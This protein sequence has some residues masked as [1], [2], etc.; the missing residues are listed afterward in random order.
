MSAVRIITT[1]QA[2]SAKPLAT[3]LPV[4]TDWQTIIDVPVYDVPVVGFGS[5][6]RIA[7]GVAE[8]SS[9][10]FMTNTSSSNV[11]TVDVR[12]VR[13]ERPLIAGQSQT[14]FVDQ[15]DAG[16]DYGI[17]N[18]IILESNAAVTVTNVDGNGSVTEFIITTG[19]E[20][21]IPEVPI[22][23]VEISGAGG[24]GLGFNIV[25]TRDDLSFT[26]NVIFLARNLRVETDDVLVIPVNG[27]FFLSRDL[28]QVR[29][30]ENGLIEATV[31]YTEG[32]AEE[33]DIT[34]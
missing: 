26:S 15:F 17:G 24:P 18:I 30:S 6:R 5:A 4:T 31:S 10:I 9:P 20:G 14:D 1:E 11:A 12:V 8:P 27:Q 21:V 3:S 25:P 33:N 23:Q 29:A 28:L 19:G 16:Q 2:P 34:I 7:P 22:A 13:A 32:Q